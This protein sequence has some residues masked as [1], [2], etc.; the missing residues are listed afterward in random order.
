MITGQTNITIGNVSCSIQFED[1][2]FMDTFG[3]YL[4]DHE[5]WGFCT[6]GEPCMTITVKE[7]HIPRSSSLSGHMFYH[8]L[9]YDT[10]SASMLLDSAALQ[11]EI[12]L[13]VVRR[14]DLTIVRITELIELFV[15]TA[16]IFYFVLNGT[17]T[18]IHACGI[19][20]GN[21]GYIFTGP[22]GY[23]KSTIAKLSS[24]RTVLCDEM[25]LLKKDNC[26]RKS[27]FGTPFVGESAG[28]N[29]GVPCG[30]I[31][32][33]EQSLS[34]ELLP[35]SRMAGVIS[36]MKEGMMG[37]FLS[38]KGIQDIFPS[39]DFLTLL[40]DL[41]EGIPCYRLRFRKDNS[42]WR[43]IDGNKNVTG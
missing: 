24:P 16:F 6:D 21:N 38:L 26:G 41:L 23:G 22:S 13:T 36:L 39:R 15:C 37:N 14:D 33:I 20:D 11:G 25:V 5:E 32:F 34:D 7:G 1:N 3:L 27:V 28:L 10:V 12:G 42:F 8:S 30:G 19:S 43:L 18:F 40:L 4:S 17:G 35:I 31:Y 9:E 29:R 2:F